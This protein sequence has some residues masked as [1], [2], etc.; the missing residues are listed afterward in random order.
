MADKGALHEN[1]DGSEKIEI[2]SERGFSIVFAG[3][4]LLIG[5]WPL[6]SGGLLR[7]WAFGVAAV[8]IFA[9]FLYPGL[10][11]PFNLIWFKFGLQLHRIANPLV[12]AFL[13]TTTIIPI[14]L[15]MKA[16]KKD[17][18][19]LNFDPEVDSYW[20]IREPSGRPPEEFKNQF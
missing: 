7:T 13:F 4:F 17:L 1:F 12:M 18:L 10:L 19:K 6:L 14:G 11:R 15:I 2:G 20:V 16:F 5:S 3:I 8:L 9:G